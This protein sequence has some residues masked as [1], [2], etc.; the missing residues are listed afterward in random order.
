LR[1]D[2]F[3]FE[4]RLKTTAVRS[5]RASATKRRRSQLARG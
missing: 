5:Y 2:P 4:T 1:L 3:Y